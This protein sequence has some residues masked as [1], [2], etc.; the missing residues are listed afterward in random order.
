MDI[1]ES[2]VKNK[3]IEAVNFHYSKKK[4]ISEKF[5]V[6]ETIFETIFKNC[7]NCNSIHLVHFLIFLKV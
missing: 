1:L 7:Q 3:T 2:R 6:L 4:H 5:S